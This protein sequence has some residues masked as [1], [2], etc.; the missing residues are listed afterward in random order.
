ML[1]FTVA[2]HEP[3]M[4]RYEGSNTK[5][6]A[7]RGRGGGGDSLPATRNNSSQQPFVLASHNPE[8][9]ESQVI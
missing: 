7:E 6:N 9:R 5:R 8:A 3:A 1:R 4:S 2:G